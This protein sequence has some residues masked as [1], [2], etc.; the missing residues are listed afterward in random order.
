MPRVGVCLVPG[1]DLSLRRL[2]S[3]LKLPGFH[4]D[5]ITQIL[6]TRPRRSLAWKTAD[7]VYAAHTAH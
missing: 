4:L 5:R 1:S 7:T 6:N 3:G 2:R